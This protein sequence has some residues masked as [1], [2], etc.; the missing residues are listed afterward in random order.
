MQN[1]QE[2]ADLNR[3]R[4]LEE[5]VESRSTLGL[6]EDAEPWEQLDNVIPGSS[7]SHSHC[8]MAPSSSV[9]FWSVLA[10]AISSCRASVLIL[11]Q[12]SL[13]THKSGL[14]GSEVLEPLVNLLSLGRAGR[15]AVVAVGGREEFGRRAASA[16]DGAA[17]LRRAGRQAVA[18]AWKTAQAS[19]NRGRHMTR[20]GHARG[21]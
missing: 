3:R 8:S 6:G 1:A 5:R 7:V 11:R 16:A 15:V 14:P 19:H 17:L 20:L 18:S 2:E 13:C 21:W 12:R 4:V 9:K 10:A